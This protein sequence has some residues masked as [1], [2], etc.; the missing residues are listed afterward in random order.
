[1]IIAIGNA[2]SSGST[3]LADLLD[4]LP[5]AVC[6]PEIKLFSVKSYFTNFSEVKRTGFYSSRSAMIYEGRQRLSDWQLC[7]YG[8]DKL[9]LKKMLN[10]SISFKDFCNNL[11]EVFS[12]LRGKECKLFF[13]KTPQ[14]IHCA[15]DFLDTF[16]DSYFLHIV[17]NPL[18]VY[19]SLLERNFP[20]YIA[21]NTWLI[22]ESKSYKLLNHP[23]FVTIYYED[24]VNNPFSVVCDFLKKIGIEYDP[25]DLETSYKNNKY[26]KI[27]CTK[28][29]SWT[30]NK[31]GISGNAN[32]KKT[33]NSEDFNRLWFMLN[34]KVSANY[35]REFCIPEVHFDQ[36]IEIYGYNYEKY[37]NELKSI[38]V[39][40]RLYENRS[41]IQLFRRYLSDLKNRQCKLSSLY[42]YIKPV[43]LVKN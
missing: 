31:Y 30:I 26:R 40:N 21:V 38:V 14:N 42:S 41:A 5:F 10:E 29:K 15:D 24:L 35:S 17:R 2:P 36:L 39:P 3:F 18:Y 6:G 32:K 4:S 11:F 12:I 43:E 20:P 37:K 19:K 13:E 23:R 27:V 9:L 34:S 16:K 8:I 28:M 33:V 1:M 22:D 7:S 25:Q